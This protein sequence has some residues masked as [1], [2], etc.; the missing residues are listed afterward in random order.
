[1][2]GTAIQI[3]LSD[4]AESFR[5]VGLESLPAGAAQLTIRQRTF[6]V[7]YLRTGMVTE[8]AR[9]AGYSSPDSDGAKVQKNAGVRAFLA[10]AATAMTEE[11]KQLI[12]RKEQQSRALHTHLMNELEKPDVVQSNERIAKLSTALARVDA[13]LGVLKGYRNMMPML[14]HFSFSV[15]TDEDRAHL[16]KLAQ[17]GVPLADSHCSH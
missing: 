8:A 4:V 15:V 14:N 16:A 13:L 6:C 3:E 10:Q 12:V 17:A 2:S 7:E 1:M 9:R 11:M 5:E